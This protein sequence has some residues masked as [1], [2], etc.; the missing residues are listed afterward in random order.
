MGIND[1]KRPVLRDRNFLEEQIAAEIALGALVSLDD[2]I[3]HTHEAALEYGAQILFD[4]VRKQI[5]V[6]STL[7]QHIACYLFFDRNPEIQKIILMNHFLTLPEEYQNAYLDEAI[8]KLNSTDKDPDHYYYRQLSL[9]EQQLYYY[10]EVLQQIRRR[11]IENNNDKLAATLS[12]VKFILDYS[13]REFGTDLEILRKLPETIEV[14][15]SLQQ[16]NKNRAVRQEMAVTHPDE[17]IRVDAVKD[18]IKMNSTR[19]RNE[20]PFYAEK[21]QRKIYKARGYQVYKGDIKKVVYLALAD[22]PSPT[23]KSIVVNNINHKEVLL[24]LA[25]KYLTTDP[26]LS[27][28]AKQRGT[29]IAQ[30]AN[31]SKA[32]QTRRKNVASGMPDINPEQG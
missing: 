11:A 19:L 31:Y 22:D 15:Y 30:R 3:Q 26:Q 2:A 7:P 13:C 5:A 23:V 17:N 9:E 6:L 27:R 12:Q 28:I 8:S 4:N 14:C 18:V 1:L 25:E 32:Y 20:F 21:I 16:E 29:Q 10:K 24:I